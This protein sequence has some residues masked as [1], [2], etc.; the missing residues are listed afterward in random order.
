MSDAKKDFIL[1]SITLR[2][3]K[4]YKN[5]ENF[6]PGRLSVL[7]G[8]NASGKSNLF[9]FFK[10]LRRMMMNP[11]EL[12]SAVAEAGGA[13]KLLHRGPRQTAYIYAVLEYARAAESESLVEAESG[14]KYEIQLNYYSSGNG[15]YIQVEEFDSNRGGS[16]KALHMGT[17]H[18]EST[19]SKADLSPLPP[20]IIYKPSETIGDCAIFQFNDTS[21]T[22]GLRGAALVSD[23]LALH[24]DGQNLASFLFRLHRLG[25]SGGEQEKPAMNRIVDFVRLLLPFFAEF[26]FS[27]ENGSI[28]LQWREKND[29]TV[30]DASQASDGMLRIIALVTLLCQPDESLPSLI[31][32]D[33]PEIGLH[34]HAISMIAALVQQ[35]SYRTQVM[36]ATQS[37]TMVDEF[38]LDDIVVVD[39]VN[40]E[41]VL[42][43][44]SSAEYA[45]WLEDFSP[46]EIWS[47]NLIGG[48]PLT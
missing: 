40:G 33:E 46:G 30:Y 2:G 7:V 10:L 17:G 34:P 41:S 8:G 16:W 43:R 15:L 47:R 48:G 5:L 36:V 18:Q 42:R 4:T 24:S 38:E 19:L 29:E 20:P 32:L 27:P 31:L 44:L 22:S 12:Q 35:V 6:R 21:F 28:A 25:E 37:V 1:E 13:S 14:R 23:S 45:T 39:R 3:F 9:S 26:V 11:G